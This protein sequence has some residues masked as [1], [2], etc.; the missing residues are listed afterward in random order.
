MA[1]GK[2]AKLTGIAVTVDVLRLLDEI[3]INQ[4]VLKSTQTLRCEDRTMAGGA[5][6]V[7]SHVWLTWWWWWGGGCLHF[8]Q[9]KD[10]I[11][12]DEGP[13]SG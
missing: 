12:Q 10:D 3:I 7:Y 1:P 4:Q 9:F 2:G 8:V 5:R 11:R 6:F 13:I